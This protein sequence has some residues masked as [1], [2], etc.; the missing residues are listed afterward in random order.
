M[1]T[2]T[3]VA[4]LASLDLVNGAPKT[5][6]LTMASDI[7]GKLH[8]SLMH[9]ALKVQAVSANGEQEPSLVID[10]D[11]YSEEHEAYQMDGASTVQVKV[12]E[13]AS[14]G[15]RWSI[16]DNTCGVRFIETKNHYSQGAKGLM[17]A[18]GQRIWTFE[19]PQPQENYVSGEEC[20][21][22]VVNKRSWE[23]TNESCTFKTIKVVVN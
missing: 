4:G 13:N 12:T 9:G 17:G 16:H 20:E 5:N 1:F 11:Q 7:Q 22:T 23:E 19:T 2:K 21:L 10:L 8:A 3:F 15:Y 18:A 14:T 6:F